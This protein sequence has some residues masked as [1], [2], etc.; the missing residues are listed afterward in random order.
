MIPLSLNMENFLC[1][2]RNVPTLD[3]TGIHLACLCGANG[4]GKSALLDA[5]TWCL[6]GKAR[7]RTHDELISYGAD[8][9]RVE[10][11]FLARDTHYRTVRIHARGG[12]RRRQG[13][14]DLQLLV[15]NGGSSEPITGNNIRETQKKID[16]FVGMDYETFTNSAFLL[17]G[18]ADEFSNKAPA[19]RKA[20]LA[21]IL[22]LEAYDRLRDLAKE[23]SDD[24]KS[25][26]MSLTGALDQMHSQV[27]QIGDLSGALGALDEQFDRLSGEL[28]ERLRETDSLRA[29]VTELQQLAHRFIEA[30]AQMGT[31]VQDMD[32]LESGLK[33]G[34]DRIQQ[35]RTLLE[36]SPT[37]QEGVR[38]LKEA[39]QRFEALEDTR[40]TYD[41]LSKAKAGLASSMGNKRARL[42]TQGEQLRQKVEVELPTKA[43]GENDLA[44]Q[45][46]RAGVKLEELKNEDLELTRER[47][48]HQTLA[49]RI[50]EAQSVAERYKAEGQE[51]RSKLDLLQR[52]DGRQAVCPLCRTPLAEDGCVR[53]AETYEKDIAEKRSLYSLNASQMKELEAQRSALEQKLTARQKALDKAR[54]DGELKLSDL[55][56]RL[57]EAQQ[58]QEELERCEAQLSSTQ[59]SLSDESYAAEERPQLQRLE[60]ELEALGYDDEARRQA[61]SRVQEW[62]HFDEQARLL[63][64]AESNLPQEEESAARAEQMLLRRKAEL[65]ALEERRQADKAAAAALPEWEAKL[66]ASEEEQRQLD[67]RRQELVARRGFLEGEMQRLG[68]LKQEIADSSARLAEFQTDQSIFQELVTAFG[69]QGVQAMLIETVIP[70]LEEEANTLLGRMTDNRMH[71]KLETQRERRTGRGDP[72]ETLEIHVGDELGPRSYEMYSGGE[73][74]R[75]NLALRIALSKVLAHRMGAPLPILFI[76]EGFGT[77]DNAGR[78]R[79]LDVIGAIQ[80]DFDKI[81]VITHLDDLKDVFPVRIEVQKEDSGST[82]WLS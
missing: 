57:K 62:Q 58:A 6:W 40:L 54:R 21:K 42:E 60:K 23:R 67:G 5:I 16:Q 27:E 47:E 41:E 28:E 38:M 74:F 46:E 69:R 77:Q 81:I 24:C 55:T 35:Y 70:Q 72:I 78:E 15:L 13:V 12:G 37:I 31:L 61:Y 22:G 18:R 10:L 25:N 45:L 52:T 56:R 68:V 49:T 65:A 1:Y 33:I 43:R 34:R 26:A 14:T 66:K 48:E 17:Q 20:V 39:R 4:H 3:F 71:L 76:D 63:S 30:Q 80:Q 82:F 64:D 7:A 29:K 79:I 73:A 59:A 9:C 32:Q 51:L 19:D 44:E 75:V 36:Q 50:G 2:R 53:L 8:Q 11:D